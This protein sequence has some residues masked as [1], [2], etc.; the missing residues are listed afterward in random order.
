MDVATTRTSPKPT[1][2]E[3]MDASEPPTAMAQWTA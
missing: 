2:G 3:G 1:G